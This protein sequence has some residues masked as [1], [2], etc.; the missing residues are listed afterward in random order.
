MN[1]D[2]IVEQLDDA[3]HNFVRDHC[4]VADHNVQEMYGVRG[5]D[6]DSWAFVLVM[7]EIDGD[8]GITRNWYVK[9]DMDD[10]SH[11]L[12]RKHDFVSEAIKGE[13]LAD[14]ITDLPL[15]HL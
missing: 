4:Q 13:D 2:L 12:L 9:I 5:D 15:R 11:E 1:I 14:S 3:L 8:D 6:P 10:E 7:M